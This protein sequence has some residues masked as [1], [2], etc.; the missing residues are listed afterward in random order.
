MAEEASMNRVREAPAEFLARLRALGRD[1]RFTG[2]QP[3]GPRLDG[4]IAITVTRDRAPAGELRHRVTVFAGL[5]AP[6]EVEGLLCVLC[7]AEGGPPVLRGRTDRRGQLKLERLEPVAY[8]LQLAPRATFPIPPEALERILPYLKG[9]EVGQPAGEPLFLRLES[10]DPA[11]TATLREGIGEVPQLILHVA[12]A[13][14]AAE[15]NLL[16]VEL[17]DQ[18]RVLVKGFVGLRRGLG[19]RMRGETALNW[20]RQ[21]VEP[22]AEPG[23]DP[24]RLRLTVEPVPPDELVEH[25]RSL[26]TRSLRA[27]ARL[28]DSLAALEGALKRLGGS[29]S[30]D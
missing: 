25:H 1:I 20:L 19:G 8:R 13:Q 5:P 28:P 7:R 12:V 3:V 26:L 17:G 22:P 30:W 15:G 10:D 27:A 29:E 21:D 16:A 11:Y 14:E 9:V 6:T 24:Q 18:S 23:A 4:D 2:G